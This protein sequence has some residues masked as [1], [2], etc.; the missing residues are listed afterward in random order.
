MSEQSQHGHAPHTRDAI[1]LLQAQVRE[2]HRELDD[3]LSE[4]LR[5]LGSDPAPRNSH[6]VA[7]YV[8]AATVED[9]TI[10][11]LLSNAS[12]LFATTWA[13]RGPARYSTTD[14]GPI[15]RYA[16]DVFAATDTYLT[17]LTPDGA[18]RTVDLSRIKLGRPT[19][20]WVVSR[21]V[22]LEL[23]QIYGELIGSCSSRAHR[24]R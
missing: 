22:V 20:A 5:K 23:A 16:Q 17:A 2:V 9:I 1:R 13:G 11:T 18:S 19:V 12:P 10:Q 6:P 4:W 7:L 15:R 3:Y 21:F 24:S 14:L 8:H